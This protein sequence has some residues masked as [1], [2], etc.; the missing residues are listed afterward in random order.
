[1]HKLNDTHTHSAY[2]SSTHS[3]SGYLG[4]EEPPNNNTGFYKATTNNSGVTTQYLDYT[5]YATSVHTHSDYASSTHT[6]SAY[7]SSSHGHVGNS[8]IGYRVT[9]SSGTNS[10]TLSFVDGI[11]EYILSKHGHS[12]SYA[13]SSHGDHYS[14]TSTWGTGGVELTWSAIANLSV[15]NG[16]AIGSSGGNSPSGILGNSTWGLP[17][18]SDTGH[19][20]VANDIFCRVYWTFSISCYFRY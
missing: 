12:H 17:S 16:T 20:H 1:M 2:A 5:S 7:A 3:H 4:K 6:H 8:T 9:G 15:A 11:Q 14:N 10:V 18:K 19:S 13:A